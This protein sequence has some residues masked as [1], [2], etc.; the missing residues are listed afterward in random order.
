MGFFCSKCVLAQIIIPQQ[1]PVLKLVPC[2]P[3]A[4]LNRLAGNIQWD[5]L[6]VRWWFP[7]SRFQPS[8]RSLGTSSRIFKNQWKCHWRVSPIA[9]KV[10][11]LSPFFEFYIIASPVQIL[12]ISCAEENVERVEGRFRILSSEKEPSRKCRL[13]TVKRN[14]RTVK[15][16]HPTHF[17]CGTF[18]GLLLGISNLETNCQLLKPSPM[19]RKNVLWNIEYVLSFIDIYKLHDIVYR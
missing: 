8:F 6:W 17:R 9:S 10:G 7:R 19:Q 12:L 3:C 4:L 15:G 13:L 5:I 18:C 11:F 16:L 1:H 14:E 2:D